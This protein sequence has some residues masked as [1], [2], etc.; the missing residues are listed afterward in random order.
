MLFKKKT[1]G[2]SKIA[3]YP[4]IEIKNCRPGFI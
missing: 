4:D 2:L 3:F 1:N